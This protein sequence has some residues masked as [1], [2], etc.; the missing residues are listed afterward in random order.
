[1]DIA[2][3]V[4]EREKRVRERWMVRDLSQVRIRQ[5]NNMNSWGKRNENWKL[6]SG[7]PVLKRE[8]WVD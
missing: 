5:P 6:V 2:S 8:S 7:Y 1:M 3:L 4:R